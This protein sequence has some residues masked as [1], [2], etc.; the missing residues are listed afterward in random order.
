MDFQYRVCLYVKIPSFYNRYNSDF[1]NECLYL[2]G[3][4]ILHH[5][6]LGE[7]MI[8]C[9]LFTGDSPKTRIGNFVS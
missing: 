3:M 7:I 8:W 4:L 2:C 6:F 9:Q 5:A 1:M